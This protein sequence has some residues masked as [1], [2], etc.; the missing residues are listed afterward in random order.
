MQKSV[1]MSREEIFEHVRKV[2]EEA[3]GVDEDEITMEASLTESVL[4]NSE[5]SSHSWIVLMADF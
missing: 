4:G 5:S 2:V 3:L 1:V